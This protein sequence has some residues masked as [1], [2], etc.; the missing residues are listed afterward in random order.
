MRYL[1]L[2]FETT[3]A[4]DE[5]TPIDKK[6]L[7]RENYPTQIALQEV[8]NDGEESTAIFSTFISGARRFDPTLATKVPFTVEDTYSGM[9]FEDVTKKL[10][11]TL[12][13]G[14]IIC[15][16]NLDYDL[17]VLQKAGAEKDI[18][19]MFITGMPQFDT[20]LNDYTKSLKKGKDDIV[21]FWKKK[22]SWR[23]PS[24]D[25]LCS[26]LG[27]DRNSGVH[28][29]HDA[30]KDVIDTAECLRIY[31]KE[32]GFW[33]GKFTRKFEA[34][35]IRVQLKRKARTDN[36]QKDTS[37]ASSSDAPHTPAVYKKSW[38]TTELNRVPALP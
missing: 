13:P 11:E 20:Q 18:D 10:K 37:C 1:I 34:R 21:Y 32:F 15:G 12:R 30:R 17:N 4:Y 29:A 38:T 25:T 24:L 14:D 23:G 5:K 22:K 6:P 36:T 27:V 28:M 9:S 7:P 31:I 19:V 8:S 2:D 26:H 3:G 16:H 35:Q 33:E